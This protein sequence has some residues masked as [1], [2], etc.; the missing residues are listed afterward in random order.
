MPPPFAV[1]HAKTNGDIR[2]CLDARELN[3]ETKRETFPIPT[4]DDMHDSK[5]FSKIDFRDA[6]NQIELSGVKD[7]YK[8]LEMTSIRLRWMVALQCARSGLIPS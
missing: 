3:K 1:S 6:E 5:V 8:V 2:A 7:E 4:L